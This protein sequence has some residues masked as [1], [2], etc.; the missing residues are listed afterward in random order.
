[1]DVDPQKVIEILA[2][3]LASEIIASAVREA[4]LQT[5]GEKENDSPP[6]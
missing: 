6:A 3:R 5:E 2:R 4:A 1:M